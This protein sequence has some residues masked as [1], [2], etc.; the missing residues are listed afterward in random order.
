VRPFKLK[1]PDLDRLRAIVLPRVPPTRV[2]DG[3]L[4]DVVWDG[5]V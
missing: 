2:V 4:Y 5:T 1:G 3:V